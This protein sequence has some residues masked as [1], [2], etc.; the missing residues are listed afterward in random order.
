MLAN[1]IRFSSSRILID[2]TQTPLTEIVKSAYTTSASARPQVLSNGWIVSMEYYLTAVKF[3]VSKDNGNT[4]NALCFVTTGGTISMI[5]ICSYG[6][7]V[8]FMLGFSVNDSIYRGKFD[9]TT[10]TNI[11][12]TINAI[13]TSQTAFSG[14]SIAVN[15]TNGH[16]TAAWSSKNSSYPNSFNIRSAKS[17]N[18]GVTWTKQ[19]GTAGVD[20]INA[21]N[22][23]GIDVTQPNVVYTIGGSPIIMATYSST[24]F[25]LIRIYK[26]NETSWDSGQPIYIGSTYTQSS[27]SATVQ[28][29]GA[30]VGRIWVAWSGKDATDTSRENIRVSYSDDNG[31]TWSTMQKLTTGNLYF[32]LYP[33]ITS[34]NRGEV[35]IYWEAPETTSGNGYQNIKSINWN[36][37]V[38]SSISY[39]TNSLTANVRY[40]ST[41][42]NYYDFEQPIAIWQDNQDFG[43]KVMLHMNGVNNSTTF[44]DDSGKVWTA[45]GNAKIVTT[46]SKFGG[47]CAYFDGSG[48]YISTPASTYFSNINGYTID[49][50][51]KKN[52]NSVEETLFD[53]VN[54]ST[55][56]GIRIETLTSNALVVNH[57]NANTGS[58]LTSS[59]TVTDTSWHHLAFVY[60]R[61]TNLLTLFLD[62]VS[63]GS[64][65]ATIGDVTT[66]PMRIGYGGSYFQGYIDEFRFTKGVARWTSNFTPP[67]S[68]GVYYNN[69]PSCDFY[70]KYFV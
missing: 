70:G 66:Y 45:N 65:T 13:D 54:T 6:T 28:R 52:R 21:N 49:F 41:C 48:D 4:W 69:P 26:Y 53:L 44:I 31:V 11:S 10:V 46:E 7:I 16:L 57:W 17:V 37:S 8:H 59:T 24:N 40:P 15:P 68:E 20:Q 2:K 51:F 36:G 43:D 5:S 1:K 60:V 9:A 61:S 47:A 63:V 38:W 18:G 27:P 22:T 23:S 12:Q 32:Q 56:N 67:T 25:N 29:Y 50:W 30:N 3:Q 58:T 64:K 55:L 39:I 14:C 42:D 19:D 62:G 35:C 34:N 33:S